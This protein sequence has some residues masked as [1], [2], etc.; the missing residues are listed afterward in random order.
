MLMLQQQASL[1]SQTKY[2]SF[3]SLDSGPRFLGLGQKCVISKIP[4]LQ[5][6]MKLLLLWKADGSWRLRQDHDMYSQCWYPI[7]SLALPPQ[8]KKKRKKVQKDSSWGCIVGKVE[9][10]HGTAGRFS[11][12]HCQAGGVQPAGDKT[13]LDYPTVPADS[14]LSTMPHKDM[15]ELTAVDWADNP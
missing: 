11:L 4:L 12:L 5:P 13:W 3:S 14:Y 8:K 10:I 1:T 15:S 2:P 6:C 9:L 7:Y